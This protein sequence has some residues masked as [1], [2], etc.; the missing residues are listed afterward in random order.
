MI[1]LSGIFDG[2]QLRFTKDLYDILYRFNDV[3]DLAYVP[4][5]YSLLLNDTVM[6]VL[7]LD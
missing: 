4:F 2:H 3:V 7:L 5:N 6:E 1:L